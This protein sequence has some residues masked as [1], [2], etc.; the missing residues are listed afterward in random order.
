MD[1]PMILRKFAI[2]AGLAV[3]MTACAAAPRPE[4]A[5]YGVPPGEQRPRFAVVDPSD[6]P[7]LEAAS[8]TV[9]DALT[10]AGWRAGGDAASWQVETVY[11]RRPRS[12]GGF[13]EEAAPMKLEEW[14]IRPERRR[15]WRRDGSVHVLGVRVV[16]ATGAE[17]VRAQGLLN[18]DG[19]LTEAQ[20]DDLA[21]AVVAG[22]VTAPAGTQAAR[23]S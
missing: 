5:T 14:R 1:R 9:A 21:R 11:A 22:I 12:V 15:W 19:P 8:R 16:D 20:L 4:V 7:E 2:C 17:I 10:T 6:R 3:A 18:G 13:A 23:G